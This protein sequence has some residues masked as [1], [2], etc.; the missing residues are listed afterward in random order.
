MLV[1]RIWDMLYLNNRKP[2]GSTETL[3]ML[4]CIVWQEQKCN[5]CRQ[6]KWEYISWWLCFVYDGQLFGGLLYG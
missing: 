2:L 6:C 3:L 4:V 5:F 1:S